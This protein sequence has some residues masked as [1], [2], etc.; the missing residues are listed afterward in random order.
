[1]TYKIPSE[2]S[3]CGT[4]LPQC[5]TNAISVD[6]GQFR[7][8]PNLCNHC[9]GYYP[10]PQCIVHC[11]ISLPIPTVAKKGRAK[12]ID[13]RPPTSPDLFTSGKKNHPFASA[14]VLWEA[15]NLLAQGQ[16]LS[17]QTDEDGKLSLLRVFNHDRG[18]IT[19]SMTD[20][21]N[22]NPPIAMTEINARAT[23]AELDIR[24]AGMHLIYAAYATTLEKPWEQ[25]FV[26]S[27]RQ[28]EDYLGLDKR[29]DL[30]KAA[31]LTLIKTIAQQP[32]SLM[33][34][35]DWSSQGK[36]KGFSVEKSRLWHL[37]GIKH[38]F[39]EDES[40]CK[41]LVGL[42]FRIKAGIWAKYFLN[43]QQ[44]REGIAFYQ[45]SSL[46]KSLLSAVMSLWQ[47]HEGAARMILWLLFK[48]RMAGL[49]QVHY[50]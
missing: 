15:C 6:Q 27:D 5:P 18:K 17:W 48:T 41:H 19:L 13:S 39:Q 25:E 28:I 7:I 42:T 50:I 43:Q 30:S 23:L 46:P 4:C 26:I 16:S 45:Y 10:E 8:D 32:C 3:G 1:M 29:K 35:I 14:I 49:T 11:P 24:S 2:C 40:G 36:V 33:T 21:S 9:E 47:Q 20:S 44:C 34:S 12:I 38:H 37:L 31:K 22:K